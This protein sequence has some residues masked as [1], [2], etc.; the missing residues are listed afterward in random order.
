[1][2]PEDAE[3]VIMA[4][5]I[6]HMFGV[7]PMISKGASTDANIPISMGIPSIAVGRGGSVSYTH[8][9]LPTI[10]AV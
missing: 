10:G 8:L 6:Y 7:T 2:Q 1:M 3:I 9:T 4:K 5:E